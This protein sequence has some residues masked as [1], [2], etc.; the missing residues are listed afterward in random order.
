MI[1]CLSTFYA[2]HTGFT[3]LFAVLVLI[4][5]V[6][7]WQ[8]GI[9]FAQWLRNIKDWATE[10]RKALAFTLLSLC[11]SVTAL[12]VAI[13]GAAGGMG[14]AWREFLTNPSV[15][16]TWAAYGALLC[17]L[18]F[19]ALLFIRFAR[20]HGRGPR[21]GPRL[22]GMPSQAPA[23]RQDVHEEP[24]DALAASADGRIPGEEPLSQRLAEGTEAL[25]CVDDHGASLPG[26]YRRRARRRLSQQREGVPM[27][28]AAARERE[29][30]ARRLRWTNRE[31]AEL[32]EYTWALQDG[33]E[34]IDPDRLVEIYSR[35]P[36]DNWDDEIVL[37]A[38]SA[39][40]I[41]Q[42]E[43][44]DIDDMLGILYTDPDDWSDDE[45]FE[46]DDSSFELSVSVE[47]E[48][49]LELLHS[50]EDPLKGYDDDAS[51]EL[52]LSLEEP[53]MP[54][55]QE[56]EEQRER[57]LKLHYRRSRLVEEMGE[58][59]AVAILRR[60][61]ELESAAQTVIR[62]HPELATEY[63]L[64]ALELARMAVIYHW[65]RPEQWLFQLEKTHLPE[66]PWAIMHR[67][68]FETLASPY[69]GKGCL[70]EREWAA[71]RDWEEL[72]SSQDWHCRCCMH[73]GPMKARIAL[74]RTEERIQE[75]LAQA[76]AQVEDQLWRAEQ[77]KERINGLVAATGTAAAQEADRRRQNALDAVHILETLAASQQTADEECGRRM[78]MLLRGVNQLL[79]EK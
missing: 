12:A 61:R 43:N 44:E 47:D 21:G 22:A 46:D 31:Q 73:C 51:F 32:E 40:P 2:A 78:E 60:A 26:Q 69:P 79:D 68:M 17:A 50:A 1:K 57:V 30:A 74:E 3:W 70:T 48:G 34:T 72:H 71:Y 7:L 9:D 39:L 15:R 20:M 35:F 41:H 14:A 13:G 28:E 8:A 55:R 10:R 54:L 18:A 4:V 49:A 58:N 53:E 59:F 75:R 29:R 52:S 25:P 38:C 66:H 6:L 19:L 56:A 63:Q 67:D 24:A 23:R 36:H 77:L 27:S 65:D 16:M 45:I 76:Q 64:N 62:I 42:D 11:G 5:L 33:K 37:P